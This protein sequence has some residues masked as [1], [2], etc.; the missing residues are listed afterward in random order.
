MRYATRYAYLTFVHRH[1]LANRIAPRIAN[2][3]AIRSLAFEGFLPA[4]SDT[5]VP[6]DPFPADQR[7]D[8]ALSHRLVRLSVAIRFPA[9]LGG[10]VRQADGS[11]LG[12]DRQHSLPVCID[13][14]VHLFL[15]LFCEPR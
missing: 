14:P 7:V 11:V 2:R 3:I 9:H 4:W 13:G 1:Y 12:Q 15:G 5:V 10:E 6:I 8:I